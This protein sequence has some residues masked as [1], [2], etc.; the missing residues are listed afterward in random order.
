MVLIS[1]V[2]FLL[3]LAGWLRRVRAPR[4]A[5]LFLPLYIGLIFI[6]PDVWSGE[7][8][9][10]PALPLLLLYAGEA[11]VRFS[12][13]LTPRYS[14]AIPTTAAALLLAVAVPG[15]VEAAHTGRACTAL[16]A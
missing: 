3:A 7:R 2:T 4:A 6:W 11:L 5:E 16:F 12:R 13:W 10:L 9:L 14:F 15:L 1:I 8:F